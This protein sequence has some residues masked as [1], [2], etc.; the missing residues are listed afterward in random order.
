MA[1]RIVLADDHAAYRTYLRSRLDAEPDIT[2]V[3]EAAD[4]LAAVGAAIEHG[5]DIVVLDLVMPGL[6]GIEATR[7]IVTERPGIKV[8]A[9]SLHGDAKLVEAMSQAGV[10]GYML[11][12]DPLPDLVE[13]LRE[14][15]RGRACFSARLGGA[16]DG[17]STAPGSREE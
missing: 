10:S 4:G 11:K 9:L 17:S 12:T 7:R 3:A 2:V 13:A 14:V 6:D 16:D 1:L 5:P 15:A 8:L